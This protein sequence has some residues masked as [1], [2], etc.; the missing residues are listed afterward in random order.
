MTPPCGRPIAEGGSENS[1]GMLGR[2]MDRWQCLGVMNAV[3][4]M[5]VRLWSLIVVEAPD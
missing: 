4:A 1:R 2:C 5:C 3:E